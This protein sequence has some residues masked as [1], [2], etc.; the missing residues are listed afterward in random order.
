MFSRI[1]LWPLRSKRGACLAVSHNLFRSRCGCGFLVAALLCTTARLGWGYALLTHEQIIDIAWQ[2]QIR[3]LLLRRFPATTAE[4]LRQAHA[5]AYGGSL[6][7]DIGY[8]PFGN[9]FF[10][11]LAHCVRTGDFV[12]NLIQESADV[13]QYA[14]ALGA[15]AHYSADLTGHPVINHCVALSFPKL[16]A[17]YGDTVTYEECPKAHMQ[18]EFGFDITQVA[19]RRY[20]SDRYHDFIGFQVSI[21]LL[22]QAFLTTYG[23][24]LDEVLTHEDLAIGTF[25]RAVS[26]IIPEMTRAALTVYHP[27]HVRETRNV[28][29][30]LFLYHLSRADYEKQW[31]TQYRKPSLF[32]RTLGFIIHIIPK[33][34]V[35]KGLAF[36]LPTRQT[37]DLYVQSMDTTISHYRWLLRQVGNG[38]LRFLNVD[39]DTGGP[40]VPGE[41]SL[42]DETYAQL[43]DSLAKRGL[44]D[45]PPDL[46][47][48]ILAFYAAGQVPRR[49][50]KEQKTWRL[51]M[52]EL[53]ALKAGPG[54]PIAL[55][56]RAR[57]LAPPP[58]LSSPK[59]AD[60]QR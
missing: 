34:G 7:Q 45:V 27:E 4:Q 39:C 28:S 55:K 31:G 30:K 53:E 40:T 33:I 13:D 46:R 57:L 8:Y 10:S 20:T 1:Q 12:S 32:A 36:K 14:F 5:Y 26:E 37:E 38:D 18:T 60:T 3:P 11:D 35:L 16:R 48:N 47:S 21:G 50:R 19:K 44:E 15:L 24:P 25:R 43:L 49:T 41:Y 56:L 54:S 42:A 58:R 51:T 6:V 52:T 22:Q 2:D 59:A 17:K 23:L 9:R 29:E